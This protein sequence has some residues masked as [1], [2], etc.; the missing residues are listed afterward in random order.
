V[1]ILGRELEKNSDGSYTWVDDRGTALAH[2][3]VTGAKLRVRVNSRNRLRAAQQLV[4][5]LLG[6]TIER[7]LEAHQDVGQAVRAHQSQVGKARPHSPVEL[8]PEIAAQFH[9]AVLTKLRSTLN[10]PIPQFKGKT[11]RQLARTVKGRPDAV[12]WLREQERILKSNPQ[13]AGLDLRPLWQELALPFQGL[14]T[15]PPR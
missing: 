7:S 12:S 15:D 11:L 13:L 14:E 4:E 10:E 8:P 6:D 9:D 1:G 3:E 2:I 5:A